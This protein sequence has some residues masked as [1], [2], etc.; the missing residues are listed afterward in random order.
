MDEAFTEDLEELFS[1][2]H[3]Q[4]D[5]I[6]STERVLETIIEPLM[7][8]ACNLELAR[9][10]SILKFSAPHLYEHDR[11][12]LHRSGFKPADLFLPSLLNGMENTWERSP[13]R[14]K[15]DSRSGYSS[16]RGS[17][18]G[19]SSTQSSNR[20]SFCSQTEYKSQQKT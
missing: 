19:Q 5:T 10:D 16:R 13:K 11:N 20:S 6:S 18:F 2:V 3:I 17:S 15:L 1:Y 12:R 14:Q 7:T 8:M 9:R 4:L